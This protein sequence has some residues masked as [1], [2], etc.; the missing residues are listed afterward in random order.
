MQDVDAVLKG[1][2]DVNIY[3][4]LTQRAPDTKLLLR[5]VINMRVKVYPIQ[6]D[7]L[8]GG[9]TRLPSYLL[10]SK[11]VNCLLRDENR[12][13]YK[14]NDCMFRALLAEENRGILPQNSKVKLKKMRKQ[15]A[16]KWG[17]PKSFDGAVPL[18]DVWKFE[19]TF[20]VRVYLYKSRR[21]KQEGG[22]IGRQFRTS[23]YPSNIMKKEL[24]LDVTN[25]HCS[26]ITNLEHY[27]KVFACRDCQYVALTWR[28][29][30][31]HQKLCRG[32]VPPEPKTP[33]VLRFQCRE[34]LFQKLAKYNI[35]ATREQ[36]FGAEFTCFDLE[37]FAERPGDGDPENSK[38][39]T[40]LNKQVIIAASVNSSFAPYNEPVCFRS[41]EKDP[42]GVVGQLVDYLLEIAERAGDWEMF[43]LQ[44]V[45][46]QIEETVQNNVERA[47]DVVSEDVRGYYTRTA[48][49]VRRLGKSLEETV[50]RHVVFAYN[51]ARYDFKLMLEDLCDV[52]YDRGIKI[53]GAIIQNGDI[54]YLQTPTLIF[55][56][57][58]RMVPP[59]LSLSA[60]LTSSGFKDSKLSFPW[61]AFTS[62]EMVCTLCA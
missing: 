34:T 39:L 35:T 56:D 55:R 48:S 15:Y 18:A 60:F 5:K 49:E 54:T 28:L 45:F 38:C 10:R 6:N 16:R 33:K 21:D 43:R 58:M 52:L 59:G 17:M 50:R 7:V 36:Q 57:Y 40:Y 25:G 27:C 23:Y 44:S 9:K 12:N 37:A 41:L 62:L 19:V 32:D 61:T 1:L 31:R 30:R 11:Y 4:H 3:E 22:P 42:K 51:S 8:L 46:D 14:K 2:D 20:E 24:H 29:F 53:G 13:E 47:G 26:L